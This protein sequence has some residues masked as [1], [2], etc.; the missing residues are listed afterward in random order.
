MNKEVCR[1]SSSSSNPQQQQIAN[2][3]AQRTIESAS[4]ISAYSSGEGVSPIAGGHGG[5]GGGG[6]GRTTE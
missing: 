3:E 6:G 5:G 4:P 2:E 1:S